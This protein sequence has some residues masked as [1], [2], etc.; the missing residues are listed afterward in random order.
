MSALGS[1]MEVLIN[2]AS[3]PPG[4]CRDRAR[5]AGCAGV[6]ECVWQP[7]NSCPVNNCLPSTTAVRGANGAGAARRRAPSLP[8]RRLRALLLRDQGIELG[9]RG[10]T[11][12]VRASDRC[13]SPHSSRRRRDS[14]RGGPA[15]A[16]MGRQGPATV[17]LHAETRGPRKSWRTSSAFHRKRKGRGPSEGSSVVDLT[18]L[19]RAAGIVGPGNC[20]PVTLM[21]ISLLGRSSMFRQQ[22]NVA[23]ENSGQG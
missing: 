3:L 15:D 10:T 4:P 18:A 23:V 22:R 1:V 19:P 8:R 7:P 2:A 11:F 5:H 6:G 17:D 20:W 13:P 14:S 12:V 21:T 16:V 9:G